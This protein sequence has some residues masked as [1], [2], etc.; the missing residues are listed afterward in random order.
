[1]RSRHHINVIGAK[2]GNDVVPVTSPDYVFK[3]GEHLIVAGEKKN[4]LNL[5]DSH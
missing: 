5:A 2:S 1:M 3:E 4:L